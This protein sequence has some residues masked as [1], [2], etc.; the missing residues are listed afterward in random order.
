M[1]R[2]NDEFIFNNNEFLHLKPRVDKKIQSFLTL[3][4]QIQCAFMNRY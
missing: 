4:N 2:F 3:T 1:S